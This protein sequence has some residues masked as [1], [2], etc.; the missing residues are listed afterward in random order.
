ML[1][2]M[3]GHYKRSKFLAESLVN[4]FVRERGLP[5]VI[6]SPSTPVGPRDI[7]P[8]ATGRIVL[9]AINGRM[10]AYVNTGLN[11]VHVDDVAT[12]HLLALEKGKIGDRYILGGENMTLKEILEALSRI[13]GHAPPKIRIPHSV[14]TAVACV[15]EGWAKLC[16]GKEPRVT[17][18]AVKMARK[19]MFFSCIKAQKVLGY[20]PRPAE[21]GLVD[22]VQWFRNNG[23]C[24]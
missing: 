20:R 24:G 23:Y 22:A 14:A 5:A 19:H 1:E 6:V 12:G 8:T 18:D 17:L 21:E 7:K 10:P 9:D 16:S 2:D 4:H 11:L 15:S 3:V 13:A